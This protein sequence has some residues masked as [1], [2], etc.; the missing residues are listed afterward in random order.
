LR[1]RGEY[2]PNLSRGSQ[3]TERRRRISPLLA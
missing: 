1:R 2:E 3:F